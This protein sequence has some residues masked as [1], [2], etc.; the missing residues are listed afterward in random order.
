[1][2]VTSEIH[3]WTRIVLAFGTRREVN[4]NSQGLGW[5][6]LGKG[7]HLDTE[8]DQVVSSS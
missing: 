6:G 5:G 2:S 3:P 1:M 8:L 4:F 7:L